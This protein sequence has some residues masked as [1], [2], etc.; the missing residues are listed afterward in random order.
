[1]S[2]HHQRYRQ[3]LRSGNEVPT[4]D[5][6]DEH[7]GS[8]VYIHGPPSCIEFLCRRCH[9]RE[10]HIIG[11]HHRQFKRQQGESNECQG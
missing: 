1:M 10:H 2:A 3:A 9:A 8:Q 7:D 4:C 5:V 6:C 11:W